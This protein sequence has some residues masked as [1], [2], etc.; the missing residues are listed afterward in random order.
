MDCQNEPDFSQFNTIIYGHNMSNNT[1]FSP[2]PHYRKSEYREKHPYVF[3]VTDSGVS[4]YDVF[5]AQYAATDSIIYGLGI[6]T[7]RKK[8]EFIRFAQ[9]YSFYETDVMPTAEDSILTLSTCT[10]GGHSKR[11]VVLC[12]LNEENSYSRPG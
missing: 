5:A 11:C 8:E 3:I 12:V 7:E 1:M 2:L 6:E 4:R 9:D 10:G